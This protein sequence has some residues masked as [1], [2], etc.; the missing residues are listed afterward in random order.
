MGFGLFVWTLI[1]RELGP[2]DF[3]NF[4]FLLT[5]NA[6]LG[7]IAALGLDVILPTE[8]SRGE[9]ES[10]EDLISAAIIIRIISALAAIIVSLVSASTIFSL[11]KTEQINNL[12]FAIVLLLQVLDIY[13]YSLLA[14]QKGWSILSAKITS[15][16]L[17]SAARIWL[18]TNNYGVAQLALVHLC[19]YIVL[20]SIYA[21]SMLRKYTLSLDFSNVKSTTIR[22]LKRSRPYMISSMA[23][24][25]YMKFDQLYLKYIGATEQLGTYVAATK[26]SE[27]W[28]FVAMALASSFGPMLAS[29]KTDIEFNNLFNT[30]FRITVATGLTLMVVVQTNADHI[31]SILYSTKYSDAKEILQIA[32]I[33][34]PL[35]FIG[36]GGNQWLVVRGR[37]DIFVLQTIGGL[38][39]NIM[40]NI[41]FINQYGAIGAA[42]ASVAGQLTSTLLMNGL[43]K[44]GRE[45]F[46]AQRNALVWGG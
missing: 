1:A 43:T 4:N 24:M 8:M 18:I 42:V 25:V 46:K 7:A 12:F 39:V 22:I 23:I 14:R 17:A 6:I 41:L 3:G 36:V 11:S 35:V 27:V 32:A 15:F 34:L 20:Y 30:Y 44:E 21:S 5:F 38:I 19:E 45:L 29:K 10:Q 26:V 9:R 37:G 33:N 28:Y 16:T 31:I 13:E 40:A 2:N